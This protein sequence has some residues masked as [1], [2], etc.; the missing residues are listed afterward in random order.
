MIESKQIGKI[1]KEAVV[2][3]VMVPSSCLPA[4]PETL[5]RKSFSIFGISA[6]IRVCQLGNIDQNVTA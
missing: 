5:H 4:S 3:S 6:E 2:A 1:C